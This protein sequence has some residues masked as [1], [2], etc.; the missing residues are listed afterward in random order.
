MQ[1]F[2]AAS[3]SFQAPLRQALCFL[4][5]RSP[6]EK[7]PPI[8]AAGAQ[9]KP[10][11]PRRGLLR[12]LLGVR[13]WQ[14]AVLLLLTPIVA[15][16]SFYA[17]W[18]GT[19][20]LT[21]LGDIPQRA[22]V[23]DMDGNPYSRLSY[24]GANRTVVPLAQVSKDF[25]K[26]LIVREDSRFYE[27]HG[28]DPRGIARALLRN[29]LRHR[30]A[31]G[32]STLTQQLARNS[33]PLGG[34]T[35]NRKIL[36][37]F[38]AVRI[39]RHYSKQQILEWYVNRIFYGAGLYGIETASQAYF[40]KP[41]SQLDL[42]ESALMAGLIRSPNRFSPL[43]NP[44]G[45][46]HERDTVLDRMVE[47]GVISRA[48]AEKAAREP[49]KVAHPRVAGV[50]DNYAMEA[51]EDEL[52]TLLSDE[53]TGE[54][55]L[56][57]YTTIDPQLQNLS[58]Q[59]VETQLTRIENRPGYEHPKKG[60]NPARDDSSGTDY[61]Q[62]A[63]VVIDN[64]T[65]AIRALVGG[66]EYKNKAFNR[67]M[68]LT[69]ESNPGRPV[70][71]TF[72]PFVYTTA[73]Q[74][75]LLPGASIN[76]GPIQP[77]ELKDAPTWAPANSDST[78]GGVQP[79]EVGL[80]RSRNTM[81]VRVGELA[82]L[83]NVRDTAEKVGLGTGIPASP[84][85]FLGAFDTTVKKLTEAYTLFPNNGVHRP[86]YFIERIDDVDGN[87]VYR[88]AHGETQVLQPGVTWMTHTILTQVIQK[89]TAAEA[90]SLGFTKPAGGKTGTT[91]D[92]KDAW[93]VGYTT[94]LT[95]GVWVGFDHPQTITAKG[96]GSAL[97]L[98]IWCRVMSKASPQR[99]PAE[100]FVPPEK[101]ER[102]RV[103]SFSNEL[104]NTG[105]EAD[106][107]A[108]T[109]DLPASRV[110]KQVCTAHQG[111]ALAE[112]GQP[113]LPGQPAPAPQPTPEP[114]RPEALPK[115]I[116]RSIGRLFGGH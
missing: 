96:Y 24:S 29:V 111:V 46:A 31:E 110:P 77:G 66:R 40:G 5:N 70:G 107:D 35:L 64:R 108:Y 68:A 1:C 20:D 71:S 82:G 6:V 105:C 62:G 16:F 50:Q 15:V 85:I 78:F 23:Y 42:S 97:A 84:V 115:R 69:G 13:L 99:Y 102:V 98:P 44:Q 27:H 47:L 33:L 37:A 89:G 61:L 10:P 28:V 25:I 39:E 91:N 11:G 81:S 9:P 56:K 54:G 90:R 60:Q 75:G 86:A 57:I 109:I 18:A 51:I 21:K 67:A 8:L 22:I 4:P 73:W 116:F 72:K 76:D 79:A 100:A 19:F 36:E 49:I 58:T 45:A 94:S 95:C 55:G 3:L 59:E 53:Q 30:A 14:W 92:F 7:P 112:P 101:I 93:F 26:A 87:T 83:D 63:L 65:G 103:C 106:G 32:A 88:A 48:Q 34:K 80:I 2:C 52:T 43:A 38:V 113:A 17:L 12:R 104:A 114:Q 41:S 74:R